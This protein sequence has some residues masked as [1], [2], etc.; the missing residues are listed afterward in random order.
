MALAVYV[1]KPDAAQLKCL[2]VSA[3]SSALHFLI[4]SQAVRR[5]DAR[6]VDRKI[7]CVARDEKHGVRL[8]RCPDHSVGQFHPMAA[9]KT[10]GAFRDYFI[11]CHDIET[12]QKAT[13]RSFEIVTGADHDFHPRDDTDR[14]FRV[15]LQLNA[16][17]GN[18]VQVVDQDVS[19]EHRLHHSLRTFSS[20]TKPSTLRLPHR[21][22]PSPSCLLYRLAR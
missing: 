12:A 20:Y 3:A 15:T 13:R 2:R 16:S 8:C 6:I 5:P 19:V 14:F 17:F 7:L 10:D 9:T 18:R 1:N 22:N 11:D 21:P 4:S